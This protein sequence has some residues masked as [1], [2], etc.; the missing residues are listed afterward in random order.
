V[1]AEVLEIITAELDRSITRPVIIACLAALETAGLVRRDRADIHE[2]HPLLTNFLRTTD[3]QVAPDVRD[4]WTRMFATLMGRLADQATLQA[5]HDSRVVFEVHA[6][7]FHSA[8]AV[9]DRLGLDNPY[10]D[11]TQALGHLAMSTHNYRSARVLFD[12]LEAHHAK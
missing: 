4:K 5:F 11:L 6:A 9:A 7:S 2:L 1:Q 12:Q 3:L 10:T 8:R